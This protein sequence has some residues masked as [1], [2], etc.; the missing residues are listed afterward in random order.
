[1]PW[2]S[3]IVATCRFR[4]AVASPENEV[5]LSCLELLSEPN[6]S[7]V[8]L[9]IRAAAGGALQ[10]RGDNRLVRPV[11]IHR[12]VGGGTAAGRSPRH[13]S[14]DTAPSKGRSP[15]GMG[16]RL[17]PH[18]VAHVDHV[19]GGSHRA[20]R[21]ETDAIDDVVR[22]AHAAFLEWR[23]RPVSIRG[24]TICGV[25]PP[26]SCGA[27]GGHGRPTLS[28]RSSRQR[29]THV[30]TSSA[31]A[32]MLAQFRPVSACASPTRGGS[33]RHSPRGPSSGQ[34][35]I[36]T[37]WPGNG[38][39]RGRAWSRNRSPPRCRRSRSRRRPASPGEPAGRT[40]LPQPD[41]R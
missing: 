29:R 14:Q 38:G 12:L 27:D 40:T 35:R 18:G 5:V 19:L 16:P 13:V 23:R 24:G 32:Q 21:S 33:A 15:L 10:D 11:G 22:K 6:T 31:D 1:M 9:R 20:E 17:D 37:S 4:S 2:A 8:P 34:D 30:G 36:R 41:I 28:G 26:R 25:V 3:A 7:P 39:R